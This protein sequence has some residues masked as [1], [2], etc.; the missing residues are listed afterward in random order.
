MRPRPAAR[1]WTALRCEP[2]A[3]GLERSP[4]DDPREDAPDPRGARLVDFQAARLRRV[5]R[6]SER[7][8]R[9]RHLA[10]VRLFKAT[11]RCGFAEFRALELR[12]AAEYLF[13]QLALGRVLR[14][15]RVVLDADADAP[16]LVEDDQV[17]TEIARDSI[18]R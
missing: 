18:G 8:G 4:V 17:E 5:A 16:D 15:V 2:P 11:A 3:D 9:T 7:R 12:E 10:K 14:R 6:V 13:V 1:R